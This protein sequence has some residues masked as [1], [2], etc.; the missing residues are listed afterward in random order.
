M[1]NRLIRA[2]PSLKRLANNS[3]PSW[4]AVNIASVTV[5]TKPQ[6]FRLL[7]LLVHL[8]TQNPAVLKT[9]VLYAS[10]HLCP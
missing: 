7:H 3:D 9:L 8:L 1:P 5:P 2:R 6:S 4:V 10:K